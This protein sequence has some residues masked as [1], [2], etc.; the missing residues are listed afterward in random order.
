MKR[1]MH[2]L[3]CSLTHANIDGHFGQPFRLQAHPAAGLLAVQSQKRDAV[4]WAPAP[5]TSTLAQRAIQ[6]VRSARCSGRLPPRA[7]ATC[8]RFPK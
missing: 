1:S 4:A 5:R 6:P 3:S 7:S 2:E 8:P